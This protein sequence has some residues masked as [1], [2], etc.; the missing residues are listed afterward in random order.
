MESGKDRKV[1][2]GRDG[3]RGTCKESLLRTKRHGEMFQL[4]AKLVS[5]RFLF[6]LLTPTEFHSLSISLLCQAVNR[7]H[8][9][10]SLNHF[11]RSSHP[12]SHPHSHPNILTCV[13]PHI[14]THTLTSSLALSLT[15]SHP[16]SHSHTH[17]HSHPHV[18]PHSLL[19][20][21]W[22]VEGRLGQQHG[23]L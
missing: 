3:G 18:D 14:L 11:S 5:T 9:D 10:L 2:G 19:P 12:H 1:D 7:M 22:R 23:M 20:D 16:H 21:R 13:L 8:K 15:S 17:P 4:R 6:L